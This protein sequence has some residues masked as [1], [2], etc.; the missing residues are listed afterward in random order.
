[1]LKSGG[2]SCCELLDRLLREIQR[3]VAVPLERVATSVGDAAVERRGIEPG[4]T[5]H[6]RVQ[7]NRPRDAARCGFGARRSVGPTSRASSR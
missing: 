7:R 6:K 3:L 5:M 1:M 4:R 2:P